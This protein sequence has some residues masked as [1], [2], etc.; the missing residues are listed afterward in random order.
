M[1]SNNPKV[2][3]ALAM[4]AAF[5][6]FVLQ[7]DCFADE[8]I[9][10]TTTTSTLASITKEIAQDKAEVYFI[11]S[12]NRDIH[13]IAPT[14]KDIMKMQAA[15]VFI[16]AGLDLEF[17]RGPLVDAVGKSE[18][19]WPGGNKQMD[20]SKGVSLLE[21]PTNLSRI[22]GD[23][24]AYGNPH[25]WLDPLNA[26]IIAQNIAEGLGGI[27]PQDANFF[28]ENAEEFAGKI[29]EKMKEWQTLAAP[30]QGEPVITYHN[31]WPYFAARFGFVILGRLE[32]KPG[33][34]PTA[35]HLAEIR[36]IIKEKKVRV[37]IR[38]AYQEKRTAEKIARATGAQV[39]TLT[40]EAGAV[41]K[42]AAYAD[43]I[44][45][46]LKL[47]VEALAAKKEPQ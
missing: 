32:P 20:V 16:H 43:L 37:I 13:F 22:Q 5:L 45:N 36:R 23:M 12:P 34:P 3:I 24:H 40:L 41:A 47:I 18:F 38:Q 10:I 26:K 27:Y 30:Y 42:D 29:D 11:A 35:K 25:Y 14:P 4:T 19:L 8:K 21:I 46:D 28:Q 1:K 33:I 2:V 39:L 6:V 15:D 9:R 7:R 17:W 44:D 31:D